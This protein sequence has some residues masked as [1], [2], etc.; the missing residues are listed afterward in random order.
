[1]ND[2]PW[3]RYV[4]LFT[5]K[6][7]DI[8]AA[9]L[10]AALEKSFRLSGLP[11]PYNTET[12]APGNKAG[13]P[14]VK[15]ET[16]DGRSGIWIGNH[17]IFMPVGSDE[18]VEKLFGVVRNTKLAALGAHSYS[19]NSSRFSSVGEEQARQ[20]TNQEVKDLLSNPKAQEFSKNVTKQLSDTL[21]AK[22]VITISRGKVDGL[23]VEMA[24]TIDSTETKSGQ[25]V[26]EL[27]PQINLTALKAHED[28][29][30]QQADS[31]I[32]G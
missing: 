6:P 31:I 28:E 3:R 26:G 22:D 9:E 4:S 32:I 2:G 15:V 19:L 30:K 5:T 23:M 24:I 21:T 14:I 27:L 10:V 17:L 8:D 20:S 18:D 7:I 25:S 16:S 12:N 29:I 11:E 1:M 13:A